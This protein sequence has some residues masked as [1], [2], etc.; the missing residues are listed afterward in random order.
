M[1]ACYYA[2]VV[3]HD[4]VLLETILS[5]EAQQFLFCFFYHFMLDSGIYHLGTF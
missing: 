1:L 5:N 2:N 4:I 3:R